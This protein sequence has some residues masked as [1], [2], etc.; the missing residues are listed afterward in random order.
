MLLK[1]GFILLFISLLFDLSFAQSNGDFQR[2][3]FQLIDDFQN[4]RIN[5]SEAIKRVKQLLEQ[6]TEHK[7]PIKCFTP[8]LSGLE[9]EDDFLFK[10]RN[11]ALAKSA[12]QTPNI[13][14]I[15]TSPSGRFRLDFFRTG[16]DSV[17][18]TDVADSIGIP[19]YIE[20]AAAELDSIWLYQV[21][22][23]GYRDR[24]SVV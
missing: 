5:K 24:K 18:S 12:N 13:A 3:E 22:K 9:L 15:F 2:A 6:H 8:L 20:R 11:V 23:L 10:Q 16:A 17:Y 4:H 21:Q 14:E 7:N 1:T 19:D